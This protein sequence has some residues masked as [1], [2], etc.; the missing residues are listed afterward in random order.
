MQKNNTK[1]RE[2]QGPLS[3]FTIRSIEWV[4]DR[5]YYPPFSKIFSKKQFRYF[6]CGAGNY[7]VLDSLLYFIIYH[8]IVELRYINIGIG[9]ISPHVASLVIVFPITFFTGFLLNRYV[10]FDSTSRT[11]KFQLT[12]YAMTVMGSILLNYAIIKIL[13]ES[14]GMWATP[15]KIACSLITAV[16]S[17]LMA[18]YFTFKE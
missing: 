17:F 7:I 6:A 8:Y 9:V 1:Q 14:V 3:A 12:R 10:V 18:R 13:V 15:A 5:F 11:M 16:Y 2:G 4:L